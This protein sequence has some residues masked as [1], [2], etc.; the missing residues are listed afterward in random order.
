MIIQKSYR[1]IP[2]RH[3]M[4]FAFDN[5]FRPDHWLPLN[6]VGHGWL[7]RFHA[8]KP[9]VKSVI[10]YNLHFIHRIKAFHSAP[11]YQ[12]DVLLESRRKRV[13]KV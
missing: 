7:D 8:A 5:G 11:V 1:S 9:Q 2:F 6:S 13:K 12:L 3:S 10:D 4:Q